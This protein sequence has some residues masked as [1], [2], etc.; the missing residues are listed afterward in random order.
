MKIAKSPF[1]FCAASSLIR[2]TGLQARSLAE[3]LE[4]IRNSS[5]ASIF[6]HTFQSLEEHHFL[7][8]GFSNDFAQWALAACNEPGL[9]EKLASLDIRHYAEIAAL[10]S[11]FVRTIE[12]HLT[13]APASASRKAFEPFH[14]CEAVTIAVPTSWSA[15]N[16][17]EFCEALRHVSIHTVHYHFV[18]ARLREPL[19]VNDF[20]YWL[21][22][23]LGLKDL[24]DRIDGIDIYTN[25]LEG[26]REHIL[27]EAMACLPA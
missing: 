1:Q 23:S 19:T 8:E 11:D 10:R 22:E 17:E 26:V 18:T 2:I 7:T 4:G 24:A 5:D 25:T 6:N 13:A 27:E 21:E 15:H 3:L 20:S 9:A 14:F 16:L 12:R